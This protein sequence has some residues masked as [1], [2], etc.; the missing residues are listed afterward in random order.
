MTIDSENNVYICENGILVYN[1]S[2][3]LFETIK[4][5]EQP[6]N[7]TFGGPDSQTLYITT[8]TS[9]YSLSMSAGR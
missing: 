4:V 3:E 1:S 2:G 8:R 5:P 7:V 9:L 6:T